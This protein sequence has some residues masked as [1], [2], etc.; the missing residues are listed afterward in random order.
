VQSVPRDAAS[1]DRRVLRSGTHR[2]CACVDGR[3]IPPPCPAVRPSAATCWRSPASTAAAAAAA[4][5][6]C[7]TATG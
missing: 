2:V 5:Y 6:R 4:T 1:L 3:R 7:P